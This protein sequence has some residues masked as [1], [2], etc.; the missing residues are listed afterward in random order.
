MG[1]ENWAWVLG[2]GRTHLIME[3]SLQS[4]FILVYFIIVCVYVSYTQHGACIEAK[5]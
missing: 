4:C 5:G 2:K 1:Y 3:P